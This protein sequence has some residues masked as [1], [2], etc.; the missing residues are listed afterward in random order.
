LAAPIVEVNIDEQVT[1]PV[2]RA[3]IIRTVRTVLAQEGLSGEIEVSVFVTTDS[4]LQALNQ[5]YR[6]I[7]A[8]TDVLSFATED[9]DSPFIVPPDT[10]RYL[11][12]IALSHDRVCAQAEEYAHPVE[13]ELT[14]LIVH[15]VLH[16]L[17]YDHER[18]EREAEVMRQREEQALETLGIVQTA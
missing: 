7:D 5:T 11:G 12:D 6:G 10:P 13:H 1:A 15:A 14:F 18:G 4:A 9:D 17:G 8:P 16:L 2:D 3:L